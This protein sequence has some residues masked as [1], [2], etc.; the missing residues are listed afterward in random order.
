[1]VQTTCLMGSLLS[2]TNCSER[3]T[4]GTLSQRLPRRR[5]SATKAEIG[6]SGFEIRGFAVVLG[7]EGAENM[8]KQVQGRNDPSCSENVR[9]CE[10]TRDSGR[11]GAGFR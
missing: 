3:K 2:C 7:T 11:S 10:E 4:A 6:N 9:L 1:M 8:S 5:N